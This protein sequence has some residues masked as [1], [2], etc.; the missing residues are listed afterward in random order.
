M[1]TERRHGDRRPP[2]ARRGQGAEGLVL[3]RLGQPRLLTTVAH[4]AVRA[5]HDH[6]RRQ[7][8][9]AASTATS[10]CTGPQRPRA[11]PRR[12]VAAV[13]PRP[14]SPRSSQRVRAAARRRGRRPHRPT[15]SGCWRAS[16]GPGAFF[17]LAAVLR[18]RATTGSS[19]RSRS[20][21]PTLSSAPARGQRLD[22]R[23]HLDRGR[24][25]PGLVA[26]A[27]RWGYLGGGLLL[28]VNLALVLCHDPSGSSTGM[29]VRLAHALRGAVVGGLHAD[30]LLRLQRPR[31][32]STWSASAA[33]LIFAAQLRPA[34]HARSRSCAATRWR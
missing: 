13:L 27:G 32:A 34:L 6:G 28:A 26:R 4:G 11:R 21:S 25:R 33:A 19:V 15:R 12:R 23:R 2:A 7:G 18:A 30:P 16:R 24:A 22:P 14:A 5:L 3:V 17:A 9:A 8:R 20:S 10:T 1:T 31:A 29:A